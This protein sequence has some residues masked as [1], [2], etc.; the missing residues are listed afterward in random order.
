MSG[1]RV[2]RGD[3]KQE[4]DS[5]PRQDKRHV[6]GFILPLRMAHDFTCMPLVLKFSISYF[7]TAAD[8]GHLKPRKV[9]PRVSGDYSMSWPLTPQKMR[10]LTYATL[11]VY[12]KAIHIIPKFFFSCLYLKNKHTWILL[13][14]ASKSTWLP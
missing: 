9:K 12:T 10:S 4:D 13:P 6:H 3:A 5:R 8:H 7:Q 14:S 2:R 11:S 1:Q